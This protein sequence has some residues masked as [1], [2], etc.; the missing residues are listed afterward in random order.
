[1]TLGPLTATWFAHNPL[2][3]IPDDPT[4]TFDYFVCQW[5]DQQGQKYSYDMPT[6]K[7]KKVNVVFWGEFEF[8]VTRGYVKSIWSK[9]LTLGTIS[10]F[11]ESKTSIYKSVQFTIDATCDQST[12]AFRGKPVV[13]VALKH[14]D[15]FLESE[16]CLKA[17]HKLLDHEDTLRQLEYDRKTEIESLERETGELLGDIIESNDDSSLV[18]KSTDGPMMSYGAN[19]VIIETASVANKTNLNTIEQKLHLT[20]MAE[21]S[22]FEAGLEKHIENLETG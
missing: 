1:L 3:C 7:I 5:S 14:A 11:E 19:R 17:M 12:L 8:K 6:I 15:D 21:K 18:P 10:A 20:D 22:A 16:A 4:W 9:I 2:I 13:N